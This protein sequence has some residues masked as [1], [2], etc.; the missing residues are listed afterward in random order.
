[1][2]ILIKRKGKETLQAINKIEFNYAMS[3]F[4]ASTALYS[5][6]SSLQLLPV[7]ITN[8]ISSTEALFTL[9]IVW[10]MKESKKENLGIQTFFFGVI[11]VIGTIILITK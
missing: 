7:S 6:V 10:L 2:A 4:F 5:M 11:M 3:G 8:S 1:L 9:L